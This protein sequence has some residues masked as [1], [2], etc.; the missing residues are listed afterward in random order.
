ME[1][2]LF[3]YVFTFLLLLTSFLLFANN[4]YSQSEET[5]FKVVISAVNKP[6]AKQKAAK[7][8]FKVGKAVEIKVEITNLSNTRINVPKG[9]GFS[10]PTLFHNGQLVPYREE[11]SKQFKKGE[12]GIVTGMLFPNPKKSQS[13]ILDLSDFYEPLKAGQYQVFLERRFFKVN[14]VKSNTITFK[15]E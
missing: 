12:G 1:N 14:N 13:E 9:V 2:K 10:R 6:I 8:S 11:I 15:V 7:E 4:A 5:N 3:S